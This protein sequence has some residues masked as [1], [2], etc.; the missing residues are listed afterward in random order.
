[1]TRFRF[2][3]IF[4]LLSGL[5]HGEATEFI[6]SG[7]FYSV[8]VDE[9]AGT[10]AIKNAAGENIVST[11]RYY[12]EFTDDT[13]TSDTTR[14][15]NISFIISSS[16]KEKQGGQL[17][18]KYATVAAVLLLQCDFKTDDPEIVFNMK[19]AYKKNVSVLRE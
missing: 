2:I 17:I 7:N 1:M 11:I 9:K 13:K 8:A 19:T 4:C 10:I 5:V 12:S 6:F 14:L 15:K 3:F 16:K 18:L